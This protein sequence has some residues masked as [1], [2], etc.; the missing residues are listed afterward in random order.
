MNNNYQNTHTRFGFLDCLRGFAILGV[1]SLHSAIN[2]NGKFLGSSFAYAGNYGVQLFFMISAFTIFMTLE[3]SA[4]IEKKIFTNFITRRLFRILPMFWVGIVIYIF[5]PGREQYN[6]VFEINIS[7]YIATASLQH[8]WH[9]F[10]INSVVPGG[11]S[12]ADEGIFYII[13]P[14]LFIWIN[15]WQRA[16]Y[17]FIFSLFVSAYVTRI[18][19]H[20][21]DSQKIFLNVD[22]DIFN[23]FLYRYFPAQL[24]VFALGILTYFVIKGIPNTFKTKNN[25]TIILLFSIVFLFNINN[26]NSHRLFTIQVWYA[27]GFMLLILGLAIYPNKFFVNKLTI[28]LG[29]ISFSF[30]LLH[31]CILWLSRYLLNT[32]FPNLL[33]SSNMLSFVMLFLTTL[34][35]T[36]PIAWLTFKFI[37]Q[38]LIKLGSSIIRKV[39]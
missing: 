2:A 30:Y 36:S 17:F 27:I 34:L 26:I 3:R 16:G 7:Y 22:S 28:F 29:R 4:K 25:G 12:I 21:Y 9:P 19:H 32:Y 37:E 38:P 15:N 39:N 14:F 24:P 1:L 8:G 33:H 13:A 23:L 20:L 10:Y 5:F 6:Q 18:Y 35:L 31:F 11:W